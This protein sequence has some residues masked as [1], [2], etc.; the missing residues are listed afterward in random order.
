[1][2][3]ITETCRCTWREPEEGVAFRVLTLQCF[4]L[5]RQVDTR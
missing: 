4:W 5:H 2:A 3:N 1:M